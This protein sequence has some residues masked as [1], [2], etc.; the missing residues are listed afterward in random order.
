MRAST[1]K[2]N[3]RVRLPRK[4][5]EIG[6]CEKQEGKKEDEKMQARGKG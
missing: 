5:I 3:D 4:V 2:Y 1:L 6:Q